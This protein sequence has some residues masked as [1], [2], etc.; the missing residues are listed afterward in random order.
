M[1]GKSLWTQKRGTVTAEKDLER[2][3]GSVINLPSR[4]WRQNFFFFGAAD[5]RLHDCTGGQFP[6]KLVP[7]KAHPILVLKSLTGD[8][9]AVVCPC[10]SKSPF[11]L[12]RFRFIQEGCILLHTGF[13]MDRDSYL[14]ENIRVNLPSSICGRLSFRGEVPGNCIQRGE[15]VANRDKRNLTGETHER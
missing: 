6:A 3:L 11:R 5:E 13:E 9:G 8:A 15:K 7:G 14:I 4:Y 2:V 12:R 10:S 1:D